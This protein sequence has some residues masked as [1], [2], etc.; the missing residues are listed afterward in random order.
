MQLFCWTYEHITSSSCSI[1]L[2]KSWLWEVTWWEKHHTSQ[3]TQKNEQIHIN[4]KPDALY[5][6]MWPLPG[7]WGLWGKAPH[8]ASMVPPSHLPVEPWRLYWH[9]Y[10]KLR[11]WPG[12]V[13]P[14]IHM[15]PWPEP[16]FVKPDDCSEHNLSQSVLNWNGDHN[17]TMYSNSL[18]SRTHSRKNGQPTEKHGN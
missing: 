16:S 10:W 1:V 2:I 12:Q 9:Y 11:G 18:M 4:Q 14:L 13:R 17:L 6:R 3:K 15:G 7:L 5:H 8:W